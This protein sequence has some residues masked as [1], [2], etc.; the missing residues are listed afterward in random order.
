MSPSNDPE[1]HKTF[2]R[3]DNLHE[4]GYGIIFTPFLIGSLPGPY[5]YILENQT[6]LYNR[7]SVDRRFSP[8]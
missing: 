2:V 7:S 1:D 4:F 6:F 8:R 3:K 5:S